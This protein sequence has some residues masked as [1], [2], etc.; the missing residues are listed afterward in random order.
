MNTRLILAVASTLLEEA[1]LAV[2]V[3]VG[4]PQL[5]IHLPLPVLI[6]LMLAWAVAAILIYRAGSRALVIKSTSGPD[7]IV[8]RYGTV[9]QPL[10]PKG[11][12]RL[13]GE[14]WRAKSVEGE[15]DN[16]KEVLV[17]ERKGTV[18]IVRAKE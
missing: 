6:I 5:D 3:L 12:I 15:I 4:L 17:V 2:V 1:A 9:V 14:L 11:L 8:G 18:L 10:N 7:D 16:D 13:G